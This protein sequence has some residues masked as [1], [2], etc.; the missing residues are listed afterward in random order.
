[1]IYPDTS[2]VQDSFLPNL[3]LLA[4]FNRSGLALPQVEG[5]PPMG[6]GPTPSR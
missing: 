3:S 6:E 2:D 1:M 5:S 4:F